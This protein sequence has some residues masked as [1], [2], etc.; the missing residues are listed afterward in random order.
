MVQ[1]D[2]SVQ[3][4]DKEISVKDVQFYVYLANIM[5]DDA[6]S[7]MKKLV[8]LSKIETKKQGKNRAEQLA[9]DMNYN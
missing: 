2:G 6:V 5:I 9:Y 4:K 1:P 7:D 3:F 8:Q